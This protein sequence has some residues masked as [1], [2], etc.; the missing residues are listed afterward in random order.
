MTSVAGK[1]PQDIY[2]AGA[3][4]AA[5][6]EQA[7]SEHMNREASLATKQSDKIDADVS[8]KLEDKSDDIVAELKGTKT[9]YLQQLQRTIEN[10]VRETNTHLAQVS[11]DLESL[12]TRLKRQISS[13]KA[14]HSEDVKTLSENLSE[15]FEGVTERTQRELEKTDFDANSR[16]RAKGNTSVTVVQQKLDQSLWETRGEE[17]QYNSV[18]FK[19]FM[20]K[21]NSIDTHFSGLMQELSEDFERHNKVLQTQAEKTDAELKKEADSLGKQIRTQQE[22]YEREIR[23]FFNHESVEHSNRLD[24]SLNM[25]THELSTM[26]DV[27]TN[28]LSEQTQILST[29]LLKASSDV[30]SA[31]NEQCLDLTS[32]ITKSM[33]EFKVRL[34][35]RT[36]HSQNMKEGLEEEKHKLFDD[37]KSE[38]TSIKEGFE[39]NLETM[40]VTAV[41]KVIRVGQDA[42]EG[43]TA[44]NERCTADLEKSGFAA[45]KE[46]DETIY[47]FLDVIAEHRTKAL[48]EIAKAAGSSDDISGQ[49]KAHSTANS[50]E[51]HVEKSNSARIDEPLKS[52]SMPSFED[53]SFD[54]E[55]AKGS[56]EMEASAEEAAEESPFDLNFINFGDTEDR[57]PA[58]EEEPPVVPDV[59]PTPPLQTPEPAPEGRVRRRRNLDQ[60]GS[61]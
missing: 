38:L 21:A 35:E 12:A 40:V 26:H 54:T 8:I 50:F 19:N 44:A 9:A 5:A 53:D 55:K 6:I 3:S 1:K 16:L 42:E 56:Q 47:R 4:Q 27:T 31:L 23:D 60:P 20:K 58:I 51:K 10:E 37:L 28:K 17:R 32:H 13:L 22:K 41:E 33:S 57:P 59:Q 45:K 11:K 48:E 30:K 46:I 34:N 61:S 14:S 15:Q 2:D 36:A 18:F 49:H 25:I 43:I 24:N 29:E 52:H 39:K 7:A